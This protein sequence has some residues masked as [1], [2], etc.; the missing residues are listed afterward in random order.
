M[1]DLLGKYIQVLLQNKDDS[2]NRSC[3]VLC[4]LSRFY[5][6]KLTK[7]VKAKNKDLKKIEKLTSGWL[8]GHYD[9]WQ[10]RAGSYASNFKVINIYRNK[11]KTNCVYFTKSVRSYQR[12]LE[13]ACINLEDLR[14]DG[15]KSFY[16][17]SKGAGF[18]HFESL[19]FLSRLTNLSKRHVGDII[20]DSIQPTGNK[21]KSLTNILYERIQELYDFAFAESSRQGILKYKEELESLEIPSNSRLLLKNKQD[22]LKAID[23]LLLP[24]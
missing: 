24:E 17:F 3:V 11:L 23:R 19:V 15:I 5:F 20:N 13:S 10:E 7:S 1:E 6:F 14:V 16:M 2:K 12:Y 9:G 21:P 4:Y 22:I 18:D 8:K